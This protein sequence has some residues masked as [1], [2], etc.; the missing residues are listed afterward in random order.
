MATRKITVQGIKIVLFE[1]REEDYLS[2]TDIAK[3]KNPDAPADVVKNWLRS[4]S[5]I[6][7][8]GFW[9]KINNPDF[10]LVEFDQF[11]NNA[12]ANAFVLSPQKWIERTDAIGIISKSGRAGGT[13][14]HK[15]IAFEFATWVSAEF[16]L[17]I[18]KEFQRLKADE[19]ERQQ[20]G[21]DV[22]R[23]LTKVNYELHTDA[24]K[25]HLIPH[26]I[27]KSESQFIYANEADVLNMALFGM[28]AAKWRASNED[29]QGNIRDYADGN[30]CVWR[31]W[32]ASMRNSSGRGCRKRNGW[33]A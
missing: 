33:C 26:V 25:A 16:K 20:L 19:S 10:K 15:D 9:E 22:K 12:G 13:Y 31:T 5:T 32:K 7:F 4:K 21:W 1:K 18:I 24:I 28:T 23:L 3:Y 17:Y 30:W 8:L 29:K 11:W 27:S 2:L 14:A 6:E